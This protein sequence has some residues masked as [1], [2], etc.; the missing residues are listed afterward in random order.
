MK[1]VF[2]GDR[3]WVEVNEQAAGERADSHVRHA[4]RGRQLGFC[5][6]GEVVIGSQLI[7]AK[8]NASG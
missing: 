5:S 8:A 4:V 6:H 7:V 3:A 2:R 1:Q